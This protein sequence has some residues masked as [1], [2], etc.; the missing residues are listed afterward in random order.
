VISPCQVLVVEDDDDIRESLTEVLTEYG[1]QVHTAAN[2]AEALRWLEQSPT[3][4][5]LILLDLMMPVMDGFRFREVQRAD[6]RWAAIPVVVLSAHAASE[7]RKAELQADALFR[8]PLGAVA[9]RDIVDQHCRNA[10]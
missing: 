4:P 3:L 1:H 9:I 5:G 7:T 2:G 6:A 8:K 10:A